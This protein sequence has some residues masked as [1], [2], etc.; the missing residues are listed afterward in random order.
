[1]SIKYTPIENKPAYEI[2][3]IEGYIA[4]CNLNGVYIKGEFI[5]D[6]VDEI[7]YSNYLFN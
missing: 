2:M 6:Y 3:H 1:M 4:S 7:E 5:L